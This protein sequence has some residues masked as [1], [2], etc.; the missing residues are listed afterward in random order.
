MEILERQPPY[1]HEFTYDQLAME[2][3]AT[4]YGPLAT[5][6]AFLGIGLVCASFGV[7]IVAMISGG[8]WIGA[9]AIGL[10][11]LCLLFGLS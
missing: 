7:A 6:I 10:G 2:W 3:R 4:A 11:A 9:P 8:M 5:G 1:A